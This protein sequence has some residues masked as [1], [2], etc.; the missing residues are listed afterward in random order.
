[1]RKRGRPPV[2][3]KLR[4]IERLEIRLSSDELKLLDR[5]ADDADLSR[6]ELLRKLIRREARRRGLEGSS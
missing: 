2:P 1:M 6:G 5:L 3:R 4:K